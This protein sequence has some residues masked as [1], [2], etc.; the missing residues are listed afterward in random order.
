L[1]D[2]AQGL[3]IYL[4]LAVTGHLAQLAKTFPAIVEAL[5]IF[6]PYVEISGGPSSV[7]GE[8]VAKDIVTTGSLQAPPLSPALSFLSSRTSSQ[9]ISRASSRRTP[10]G[11]RGAQGSSL[12]SNLPVSDVAGEVAG[13]IQSPDQPR[14][15]PPSR[16]SVATYPSLEVAV[17]KRLGSHAATINQNWPTLTARKPT[18]EVMHTLATEPFR[19]LLED[20]KLLIGVFTILGNSLPLSSYPVLLQE[21]LVAAGV[22]F[23]VVEGKPA[24]LKL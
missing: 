20:T 19:A 9:R 24:K 3:R 14:G 7:A 22:T 12:H 15:S 8:A 1:D 10:S 11:R 17:S 16:P 18:Q 2:S 4:D 23:A 6:L 5:D 13:T 21:R